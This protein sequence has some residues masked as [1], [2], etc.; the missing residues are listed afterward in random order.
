MAARGFQT[1][2][3][4]SQGENEMQASIY[5][6]PIFAQGL[7]SVVDDF[8]GN[9]AQHAQG[10]YLAAKAG[11]L[12]DTS[13]YREAIGSTGKDDL[14][15]MLI[16][17]L[18]AG[19]NYSGEAPEILEAL[20][21]LPE[22]AGKFGGVPAGGGGGYRAPRVGNPQPSIDD[23]DAEGLVGAL[24][25]PQPAQVQSSPI[26]QPP[27]LDPQAVMDEARRAIAGGADKLQVMKRLQELGFAPESF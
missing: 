8:I 13:R 5:N 15:G 27:D 4:F 9:P 26:G 2:A 19:R 11:E 23:M 6:N 14:P 17:A 7:S 24:M 12:A 1:S 3:I 10:R 16:S 18:Q 25:N 20:S 22:M 21:T